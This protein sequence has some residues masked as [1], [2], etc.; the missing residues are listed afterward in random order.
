MKTIGGLFGRSAFGPL[1]EQVLK[2]V[3][4][5]RGVTR[6]VTAHA[7]GDRG[8]VEAI[9]AELHELESQADSIK[10]EIRRALSDSL[11]SSVERSDVLFLV[12]HIDH[13]ADL[14]EDTA[15]LLEVRDTPMPRELSSG[16]IKLGKR[17]CRCAEVLSEI[18]G[19][20]AQME[21]QPAVKKGKVELR[22]LHKKVHKI[23]HETD[24]LQH[25][26]VKRLFTLEDVLEPMTVMMILRISER[27]AA[28]ADQV[29]NNADVISRMVEK[30]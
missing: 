11:F 26:L 12:R 19:V 4:C 29:E 21:T 16:Y 3:D 30:L 1:H 13:V 8:Q 17:V 9:A 22:K 15:K 25:A 20:L 2:T 5:T 7:A 24:E 23:E 27:L 14:C 18:T 28:I 10:A 6:L